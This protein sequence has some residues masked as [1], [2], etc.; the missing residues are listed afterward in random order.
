[1]RQIFTPIHY[2][3]MLSFGLIGCHS[4]GLICTDMG[5]QGSVQVSLTETDLAAGAYIL[6]I[7]LGH[8]DTSCNFEVPFEPSTA[9]CDNAEISINGNKV[10]NNP[11]NG[12]LLDSAWLEHEVDISA[13]DGQTV[14]VEY[15]LKSDGGLEFGG[16]NIDDFSIQTQGLSPTV[17]LPTHNGSG[18]VG[19]TS[20]TID[21]LGQIPSIGNND[22]AVA[23]K[24]APSETTA[25]VAFGFSQLSLPL[26]GITQLVLPGTIFTG[27]TDLFGQ[28]IV[29]IPVP[30][31]PMFIGLPVYFQSLVVDAGGPSGFSATDGLHVIVQ[32]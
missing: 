23:L 5:C 18:T 12:N 27:T 19:S 10:W 2:G 13:Y 24:N 14:Q 22:F 4:L 26:L 9:S 16:W 25:F 21:S 6:D 30:N 11:A 29:S 28:Y 17:G 1:M 8:T 3:F 7:D 20:P 32:P 31:D 15:R